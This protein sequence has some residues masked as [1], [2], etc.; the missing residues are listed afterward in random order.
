MATYDWPAAFRPANMAWGILKAGLQFGSPYNGTPQAVDFVAE[1]WLISITLPPR[2]RNDAGAAE[3]FFERMAGG[4]NWVRVYHFA[5]PAPIGTMRGSPVLSSGVSRG[6][7]SLPITTTAGATVKAGDM[8][9]CGG[10][11]FKVAEDATANGSG[12]ITVTLVN[13]VRGTINTAAAVT[14]NMPTAT[15]ILP[16]KEHRSTHAAIMDSVAIDLVE[17]W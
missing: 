8:L 14:W 13:R 10:Q 16:S 4:V 3:A 12:A 11:L 9:G 5:R 7:T 17:V 6:G 1:R 15:F 2:T